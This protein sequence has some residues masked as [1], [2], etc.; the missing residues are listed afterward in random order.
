MGNLLLQDHYVFFDATPMDHG[1]P[2]V[3]VGIGKQNPNDVIGKAYSVVVGKDGDMT[4]GIAGHSIFD[5]PQE[6]ASSPA[7]LVIILL[8]L[9]LVVIGTGYFIYKK[10][11]ARLNFKYAEQSG[12]N[13][14]LAS[15]NADGME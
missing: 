6:L 12:A 9:V 3:Q 8:L 13:A 5:L 7:L 15:V 4:S 11:Q 14:R 2:Y 1:H 10:K